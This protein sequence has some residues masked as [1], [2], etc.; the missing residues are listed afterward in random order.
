MAFSLS[1]GDSDVRPYCCSEI[2]LW[3]LKQRTNSFSPHKMESFQRA[4][5]RFDKVG[6]IS[7]FV[8]S[9]NATIFPL[10]IFWLRP[11]FPAWDRKCST[12]EIEGGE[13][14]FGPFA[15]PRILGFASFLRCILISTKILFLLLGFVCF[16]FGVQP[17]WQGK[18]L[19][20]TS[21]LKWI[22][23]SGLGHLIPRLIPCKS[24]KITGKDGKMQ[25]FA[26][27]RL[28]SYVVSGK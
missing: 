16:A 20:L 5:V 26:A 25:I 6:I 28:A 13:K 2:E 17:M 10:H 3:L 23:L 18:H 9:I 8:H 12:G 4:R 19:W 24:W 7:Y 21:K 22:F 15:M 11:V 1:G 14:H 27:S